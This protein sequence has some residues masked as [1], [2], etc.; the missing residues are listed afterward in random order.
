MFKDNVAAVVA[1]GTYPHQ[2]VMEV[3]HHIPGGDRQ[4]KVYVGGGSGAV[5]RAAGGADDYLLGTWVYVGAW[6]VGC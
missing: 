3:G 2:V 5:W 6:S 4:G 1:E